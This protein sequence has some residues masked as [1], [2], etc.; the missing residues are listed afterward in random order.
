MMVMRTKSRTVH[1]VTAAHASLH[2]LESFG[3][4]TWHAMATLL[5]LPAQKSQGPAKVFRPANT[6]KHA[7]AH[8]AGS[9]ITF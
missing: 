3:C 8:L 9:C 7:A 6:T 4:T 5:L 2:F 1:V